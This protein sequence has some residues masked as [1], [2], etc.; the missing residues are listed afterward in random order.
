MYEIENGFEQFS[1]QMARRLDLSRSMRRCALPV[2]WTEIESHAPGTT[3][4]PSHWTEIESKAPGTTEKPSDQHEGDRRPSSVT[5]S[6]S[7]FSQAATEDMQ[8]HLDDD[9][10]MGWE[11]KQLLSDL[12]S[13]ATEA[14]GRRTALHSLV[15][16][17]GLDQTTQA[18]CL[19]DLDKL[20][21]AFGIV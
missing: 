11:R 5:M 1:Q 21:E 6:S 13:A 15:S 7:V 8:L 2:T 19:D 12:F 3:S 14:A 9:D 16:R 20:E 18:L 4:K 17:L 10:A